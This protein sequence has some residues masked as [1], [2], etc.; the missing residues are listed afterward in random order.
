MSGVQ[1]VV[2]QYVRFLDPQKADK[3]G[4]QRE[5]LTNAIVK[6]LTDSN[7]PAIPTSAAKPPL[8][9]VARIELVPEISTLSNDGLDCTSWVSL[10]AQT[11]SNVRIAPIDVLRNVKVVYW[12]Q[13]LLLATAQSTHASQVRDSLNIMAQQFARQ[14]RLDQPPTLPKQ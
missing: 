8:M 14:Y 11:Q 3:C 5:P 13:G 10:S 2:V 6:M 1:E 9:G 12:Q 4:L 7:A